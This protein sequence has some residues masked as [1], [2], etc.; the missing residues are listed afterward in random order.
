MRANVEVLVVDD[1]TLMPTDPDSLL[2]KPFHATV[3]RLTDGAQALHSF[4]D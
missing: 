2:R 3:L 1:R 4:S